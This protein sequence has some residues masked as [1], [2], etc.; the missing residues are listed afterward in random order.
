M[1]PAHRGA[2]LQAFGKTLGP[3]PDIDDQRHCNDDQHQDQRQV[4]EQFAPRLGGFPGLG[5]FVP[6]PLHGV[7]KADGGLRPVA[8]VQGRGP[9]LQQLVGLAFAQGA[10]D[11][12]DQPVRPPVGLFRRDPGGLGLHQLAGKFLPAGGNLVR[13]GLAFRR[14]RPQR[15]D[16]LAQRGDPRGIGTLRALQRRPPLRE[17]CP[18]FLDPF[19]RGVAV[20]DLGFRPL[21][22]PL[23]ERIVKLGPV[24]RRLDGG[25]LPRLV[26]RQHR[27]RCQRRQ[28][29]PQR[30]EKPPHASS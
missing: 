26:L 17:L 1:P 5:G 21:G 7:G 12:V 15:A 20:F 27:H 30:K 16:L 3:A 4:V 14:G 29:Q 10:V 28:H 9:E 2:L 6:E 25:I 22:H 24:R 23:P 8:G 13:L 19:G 18:D 11:L